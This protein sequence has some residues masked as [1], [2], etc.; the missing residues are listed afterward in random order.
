MSSLTNDMF[1]GQGS[2]S[3]KSF[4]NFINACAQINAGNIK[5]SDYDG[6]SLATVHTTMQGTAILEAG[7]NSLDM[8]GRPIDIL[9]KGDSIEP[10]GLALHNFD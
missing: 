9:Y 3:L 10:I 5:A 4:E 1:S 2:Y 8:D 6:R 7:I